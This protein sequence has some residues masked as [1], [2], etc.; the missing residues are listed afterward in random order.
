MRIQLANQS[1]LDVWGKGN[2]VVGKLYSE[3]LPELSN[4]S[5]FDQLDG[6]YTTG[7]PFHAKNQRVDLVADGLL[8]PYYFNYSF[9][10][11]YNTDGQVYGVMNT[12]AEITDLIVAKQ[13]VEAAETALRGAIDLAELVTWSLDIKRGTITYSQR[14]MDWLGF[15]ED[16]KE[17]DEAYNPLPDQYR[18]SVPAALEATWQSG[19]SGIYENEHPVVNRLTGQVRIIHAQAQ[20][21]YDAE[22]KPAFLSGMAQD[23]TEQRRI[24]QELER[25]VAERT[26]QLQASVLDLERSNQNLQ[27]FAYIASHDLQEPLRKIQ[28]FGD[29]LKTQYADSLGDGIDLL[30]RMQVAASR[31]SVLIKDLLAF[32]RISTRQETTDTVSL[33]QV[34]SNALTDLEL[35]V[36]ETGAVIDAG[37]LPTVQGDPSQL[38]QLFQNLISNALKF[39]RADATG[40]FVSPLIRI[41][42]QQLPATDLPPSVRPTRETSAY[43]RIDV[44]DNGIGFEQ[45]YVDRIF[46]VFQRLHGRK[47]FVGTGIGLAICE[48]VVANH[49]GAITATSQPGQGAT[50]SVYLPVTVK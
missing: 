28:S 49:G 39:R 37:P 18:E 23:V 16:T 36:Q 33:N 4:Q 47:E 21:S 26:R 30:Q 31:M 20:V 1:I 8:Q 12:A 2:D 10:P 25:Q 35:A 3:I 11:L 41:R 48:K 38:G 17:L 15:S 42:S 43:H 46:Q 19:A 9:T 45:K 27:Q 22:G 32:S 44:V 24:Q 14:F 7:I 40:A 5:I 34:I 50:F 13:Q 6:V 29:I